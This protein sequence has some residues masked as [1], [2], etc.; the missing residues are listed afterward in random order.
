MVWL[1]EFR[2]GINGWD[3]KILY[4]DLESWKKRLKKNGMEW[5]V[6]LE[7]WMIWNSLEWNGM[8]RM[9]C[10]NMGLMLHFLHVYM[11]NVT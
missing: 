6:G 9:T 1:C 7:N 8:G 11:L 3:L 10:P 5:F 4:R 2:G